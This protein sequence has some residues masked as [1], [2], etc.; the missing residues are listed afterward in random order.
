MRASRNQTVHALT[1]ADVARKLKRNTQ[2]G[3]PR[4]RRLSA[5]SSGN[6]GNCIDERPDSVLL[7]APFSPQ[8]ATR[9]PGYDG[10]ARSDVFAAI[11]P[12]ARDEIQLA[13]TP[14]RPVYWLRVGS[15]RVDRS[16]PEDTRPFLFPIPYCPSAA[17][18]LILRHDFR[19]PLSISSSV[20][21]YSLLVRPSI[22]PDY[23]P[24]I[25]VVTVPGR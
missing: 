22:P 17:D 10:W 8:L 14:R 4:E 12:H 25:Q 24:I 2:K 16:A 5:G 19:P 7:K 15:L 6:L 21:L 13:S 3:Q 11:S 20:S 1:G 18:R 23:G 9:H